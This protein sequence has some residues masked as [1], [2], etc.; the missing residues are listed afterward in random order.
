MKFTLFLAAVGLSA[1]AAMPAAAVT[2]SAKVLFEPGRNASEANIYGGVTVESSSSIPQI[3]SEPDSD[4]FGVIGLL[5]TNDSLLVLGRTGTGQDGFFFETKNAFKVSLLRL[6]DEQQTENAR[7]EISLF[8][9]SGSVL[10]GPLNFDTPPAVL[11]PVHL[12]AGLTDTAGV[13]QIAVNGFQKRPQYDLLIE[14][15][16]LPAGAPLAL[17]AFGI[18][19]VASRARHRKA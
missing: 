17:G 6:Q 5:E 4:D 8:D 9:G 2:S 1:A 3:S 15:I 14:A 13:Y 19:A 7:V 16:P 11:S 12:F 10:G 18:W